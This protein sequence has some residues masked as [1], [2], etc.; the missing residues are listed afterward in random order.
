MRMQILRTPT[1]G[2]CGRTDCNPLHVLPVTAFLLICLWGMATIPVH[3]E[4]TQFRQES[5]NAAK[6]TTVVR[7]V[8]M[9]V[10]SGNVVTLSV[11]LEAQGM[12]NA[13]GFSFA[14]DLSYLTYQSA[15]RGSG[16]PSNAT[17]VRNENETPNGKLGILIGLDFMETFAPGPYEI[18]RLTFLASD[19]LTGAT[20]VSFGDVPIPR[21]FSTADAQDIS[22]VLYL[23]GTVTLVSPEEGEPP[24][25]GEPSLEGEAAAEGESEPLSIQLLC[26]TLE[27]KNSGLPLT[28]RVTTHGG[29]G[30]ITYQW[31][32]IHTD[33][34]YTPLA[35]ALDASLFFP[36]LA[37]EDAGYYFCRAMDDFS[38]VDS[39]HIELVVLTQLPPGPMTGM[40]AAILLCLGTI[41]FLKLNQHPRTLARC[42]IKFGNQRHTP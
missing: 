38:T 15:L 21:S 30:T 11:L 29:Q 41:S 25:E 4:S 35:D 10:I 18:A 14:F 32:R 36:E 24:A 5:G 2:R 40:V 37:P 33:E 20:L 1:T 27:Y 12:E 6:N 3:A 13:A 9:E 26:G 22:D 17:F 42:H 19:M 7:I 28:L 39:E 8:P 34:T 16:L 31:Y 23:P